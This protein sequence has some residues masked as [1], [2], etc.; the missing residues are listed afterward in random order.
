VAPPAHLP[1][2]LVMPS[3][4]G[5]SLIH[6]HNWFKSIEHLKTNEQY[7]KSEHHIPVVPRKAVA[8]V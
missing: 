4:L 3:G 5:R 2:V 6:L 7:L 1:L 8:E